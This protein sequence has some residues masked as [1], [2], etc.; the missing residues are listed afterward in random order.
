ME[1]STSRHESVKANFI[2]DG[3]QADQK[4]HVSQCPECEGRNPDFIGRAPIQ[5]N[6]Q[7][8]YP[9]QK[10]SFD[11]LTG[12]PVTDRGN[13]VLLTVVDCFSRSGWS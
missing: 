4:K 5:D 2:W 7:A 8:A 6:Y 13:S 12:L 1:S 9:F 3:M 10:V 11:L